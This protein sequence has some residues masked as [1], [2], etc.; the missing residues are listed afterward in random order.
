MQYVGLVKRVYICALC[1]AE[2]AFCIAYMCSSLFISI[3]LSHKQ[4]YTK[5][6]SSVSQ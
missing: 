3:L 2:L 4:V 5:D 6:I 1:V